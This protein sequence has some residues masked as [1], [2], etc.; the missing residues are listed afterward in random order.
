METTRQKK[1]AKEMLRT[2]SALL[3][4]EVEPLFD[5]MITVNH[6]NVTPDLQLVRVY[7]TTLAPEKLPQVLRLLAEENREFR[8]RLAERIRNQ[9][10]YIPQ[11]QF[12]RDDTLEKASRI[13]A[14]FERIHA[15]EAAKKTTD[16]NTP[17]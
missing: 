1:F 12:Y 4:E 10:R 11:V 5:T 9:V 2:I 8:Q 16:P 13:D 17:S 14:L 3:R 15:E 6:V 7:L